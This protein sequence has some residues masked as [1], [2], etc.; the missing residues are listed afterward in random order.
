VIIQKPGYCV[1]GVTV[2]AEGT[3]GVL[4]QQFHD[5]SERAIRGPHSLCFQSAS[6]QNAVMF[7][8]GMLKTFV[9]LPLVTDEQNRTVRKA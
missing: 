1:Q 6:E 4:L 9:I 5:I 7:R 3:C 2:V 8:I